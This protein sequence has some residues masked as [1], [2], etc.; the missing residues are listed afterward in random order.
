M[1]RRPRKVRIFCRPPAELDLRLQIPPRDPARPYRTGSPHFFAVDGLDVEIPAGF[2]TD[3]ASVPRLLLWL[4]VPAGGHQRAA[5]LHDWL[6]REQCYSR[7]MSDSLFRVWLEID[8]IPCWRTWALYYAVRLWGWSA[9][10]RNAKQL[11][12][13]RAKED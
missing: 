9:W 7:F 10:N 4:F 3:L 2:E 13:R 11:A 12:E 6:Y 8:E 5:L 1:S